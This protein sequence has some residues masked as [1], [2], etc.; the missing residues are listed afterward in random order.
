M[1]FRMW[2]ENI[3]KLNPKRLP[4]IL[5]GLV[6]EAKKAG[7]FKE[8]RK[9]F[10]HQ[11]KHGLYWHWTDDPNYTIDPQKGPM[12]M[13]SISSGQV[14]EG[15]LMISSDIN[16]W[17]YYG[18]RP[19]AAIIDMTAVPRNSYYQVQRGFGNEFF[20]SD[21]SMAA[22]VEVLPRQKA[23]AKNKQQRRY[24]ENTIGNEE[25]LQAFYDFAVNQY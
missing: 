10:L 12:D 13:S 18:N 6:A 4:L 2:I 5:K 16:A 15:K 24:L 19:Y 22:V 11:I 23:F 17:A 9:D 3:E 14:S 20:V 1:N 8:F 25:D 21:P 7:S